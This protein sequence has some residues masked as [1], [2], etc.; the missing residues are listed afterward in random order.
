MMKR[1]SG[2]LMHV[3]SLPS[4]FGIGDLG[5]GAYDF[6]NFLAEARQG[7][8]QILPLNPTERIHGNS[9]Y[10]S[11]SAFAGNPLLISP[12][13]LARDGFL[14][15]E[16]MESPPAFPAGKADYDAAVPYKD[17]LL[18]K[19]YERFQ[20]QDQRDYEAFCAENQSWL[21]DFALFSVLKCRFQAK[22][23]SEWPEAL[24]DREPEALQRAAEEH[25]EALRRQKFT[26]YLFFRQWN[27]LKTYCAEKGVRILGDIPIYVVYDSVDVWMHPEFFHLDQEKR[28]LTVAGVP[29]DYF[30]ETGQ[31]WGNPVYRWDALKERGYDWWI[32]RIGH[33]LRLFDYIR[34][35]HFR[36]F[37]GY[38]EVPAEEKTAVNGK[39]VPAPADD[40]FSVILGKFPNA[41]I[42]AED[43]GIITPDV[44]EIMERFQFPGMKVLLFAF[45]D[46]PATNPYAPHNHVKNCLAYTGTHDNNTARGWF[47]NEAG[48]DEKRRLFSYLGREVGAEEIHWALIRL[49]MMSIAALVVVPMQDLLGLGTEARM[50]RPATTT[51]NWKW[52]LEPHLLMSYPIHKILEVTD[53]YGRASERPS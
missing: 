3:T 15:R 20:N 47:E 33:N 51:G 52:R 4:P 26:Q 37:V 18:Q 5:P 53:I 43:L 22:I 29:P 39:W 27:S 50:N 13:L 28:P 10:H 38:W 7:Y 24:R 14:A 25:H 2:V 45:G 8:W 9:P 44:T 16:E 12:E 31:L 48:P 30:S 40:F 19:A 35:D 6:V 11:S 34:V 41:P 49:A 36:G 42:I 23:W 46:D 32:R 1:G 17:A 21:D